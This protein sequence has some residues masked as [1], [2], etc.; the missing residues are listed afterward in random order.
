MHPDDRLLLGMRW[1]GKLYV[2]MALPF[3]LRSAPKIFT[4]LADALHWILETHGI[5]GLHYLDD[6]LIFADEEGECE[7]ALKAALELFALLGVAVAVHKTDGP[8]YRIVFLGIEL[9]TVERVLR[10]P[11]E[12]L[13]KLQAE[14]R[15]WGNRQACTKRELLSLIGQLQH[16]W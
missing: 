11:K 7:E 16:V 10:L 12:K 8:A 2:D 6:F 1:K 4:A 13:R 14:I 9:D 15:R 5:D 3:G